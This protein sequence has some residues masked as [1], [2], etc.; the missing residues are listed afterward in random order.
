MMNTMDD[1][2][3][4]LHS[5]LK[6]HYDISQEKLSGCF[7]FFEYVHNVRKRGKAVLNSVVD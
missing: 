2:W 4:L 6:S 3:S 5:C 7:E 1:F